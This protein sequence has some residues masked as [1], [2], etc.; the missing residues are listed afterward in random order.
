MWKVREKDAVERGQGAFFLTRVSFSRSLC[1]LV[2]FFCVSTGG[3]P[4]AFH[5]S[6]SVL[7]VER[8]ELAS[9]TGMIMIEKGLSYSTSQSC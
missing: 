1:P 2:Y 5:P 3:F 4:H 9:I 7:S 8:V 6:C